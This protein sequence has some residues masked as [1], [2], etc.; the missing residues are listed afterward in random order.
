MIAGW[1]MFMTFR[2]Q[3]KILREQNRILKREA[4]RIVFLACR[5]QCRENYECFEK[6]MNLSKPE[7]V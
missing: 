3:M 2:L 5:E 7:V 1:I 4:R 6:C